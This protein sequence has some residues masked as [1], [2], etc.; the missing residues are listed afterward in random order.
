[1]SEA[2]FIVVVSFGAGFLSCAAYVLWLD[3]WYR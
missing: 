1:M 2:A 3:R